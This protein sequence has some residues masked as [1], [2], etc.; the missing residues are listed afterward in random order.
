[1]GRNT[2]GSGCA[3]DLEG[4]SRMWQRSGVLDSVGTREACVLEGELGRS[5]AAESQLEKRKSKEC[6]WSFIKQTY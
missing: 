2:S 3:C 5:P 1:M 4:G 6:L